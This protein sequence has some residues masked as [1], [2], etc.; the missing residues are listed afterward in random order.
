[1]LKRSYSRGE[2][3]GVT[4]FCPTCGKELQ[5]RSPQLCMSCGSKQ[6]SQP[7]EVRDPS[8]R[9][10]ARVESPTGSLLEL[11]RVDVGMMTL[12]STITVGIYFMVWLY[13]AMQMYRTL[14]GR[15]G[16]NLEQYFWGTVIAA[17]VAIALSLLTG[18]LG[19]IAVIAVIVIEALLINEVIKD[20][21]AAAPV[22]ARAMLPSAGLLVTLLTL[23][24]VVSLTVCGLIV[25]I[26]LAI[27]FYY[28]FFTG[29]NGLIDALAQESPRPGSHPYT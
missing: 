4:V 1:M 24:Y 6:P 9:W 2:L 29:H 21:D 13:K 18:F 10:P 25:G 23:S 17:G 14:S 8:G 28:Q 16:A 3:E 11:G 26:P 20:R 12:L 15:A 19:L 22:A 5:S 7:E 27:W